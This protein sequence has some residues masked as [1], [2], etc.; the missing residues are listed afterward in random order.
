VTGSTGEFLFRTIKPGLYPSR[1]RHLHWGITLPGQTRRTTTQTGWRE[2]ALDAQGHR[3]PMQSENDGLFGSIQDRAQ[4][5]SILLQFSRV[6]G[7]S[8]GE[9]QA[10]WDYVSGFTPLEPS[11]PEPGGLVVRGERLANRRFR[12]TFRAQAG[13]SYEVYGNPAMGALSWAALPFA[14][15][16]ASQ[17]DRNLHTAGTTGRL[18]LYVQTPPERSFY[19]V[20]FRL[21]GA[22]LGTP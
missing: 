5:D 21:P 20:A 11:Y 3:A 4:L 2:V 10:V 6:P 1:A 14:L 12:I 8:A 13:Y 9:E 18:D 22:N 7:S 16:E 17:P 15:N 19:F